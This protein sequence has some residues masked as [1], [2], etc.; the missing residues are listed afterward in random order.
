MNIIFPFP[1]CRFFLWN[2]NIHL[3][4]CSLPQAKRWNSRY[5][6]HWDPN[7]EILF[8]NRNNR[9]KNWTSFSRMT[10]EYVLNVRTWFCLNFISM[11]KQLSEIHFPFFSEPKWEQAQ[12]WILRLD[13]S[14]DP[15]WWIALMSQWR[16]STGRNVTSVLVE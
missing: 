3:Q 15:C 4:D 1:G 12:N 8:T 6:L 13:Q 9:N 14:L 5:F 2:I 7:L 10:T 11:C 16:V